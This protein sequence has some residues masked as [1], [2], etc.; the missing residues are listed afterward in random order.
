MQEGFAIW[1][2]YRLFLLRSPGPGYPAE[3]QDEH[4][5][6]P[7]T[8]DELVRPYPSGFAMTGAGR[9]TTPTALA[10][11]AA[12][13]LAAHLEQSGFVVMKRPD[14][15][16]QG[17]RRAA[18]LTNGS[19][20]FP[21]SRFRDR[22]IAELRRDCGVFSPDLNWR[23][24]SLARVSFLFPPRLRG[25]VPVSC[26]GHVRQ[27]CI[28]STRAV[29]YMPSAGFVTP[30]PAFIQHRLGPL[31]RGLSFSSSG[32]CRACTID[33]CAI[34]ADSRPPGII[35][36]LLRLPHAR[37]TED[38]PIGRARA[39]PASGPRGR[40]AGVTARAAGVSAAQHAHPRVTRHL[41]RPTRRAMVAAV[42]S[43]GPDHSPLA[44]V[45]GS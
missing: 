31:R 7:A 38:R 39:V 35:T 17:C 12:E 9:S 28:A 16:R 6:R 27:N 29:A 43:A 41:D 15:R 14:V 37:V 23:A 26:A 36:V 1:L 32:T 13:R 11:V 45:R 20:I 4:R 22:A 30:L 2:I 19:V 8:T 44:F 40:L 42:T 10:R 34:A 18:G 25:A 33:S 21:C 5:L 24:P 3:M